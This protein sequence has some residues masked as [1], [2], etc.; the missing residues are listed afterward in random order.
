MSNWKKKKNS[1]Y[2]QSIPRGP[3]TSALPRSSVW[4][5]GN[6]LY[7]KI[8]GETGHSGDKLAKIQQ[9]HNA[10]TR[11]TNR[12]LYR[13]FYNKLCN[14]FTIIQS[15]YQVY[16]PIWLIRCTSNKAPHH[17]LEPINGARVCV[18]VCYLFIVE[19][20]PETADLSPL[21][22]TYY[23]LCCSLL[24]GEREV[25]SEI[26]HCCVLQNHRFAKLKRD[27]VSYRRQTV[28]RHEMEQGRDL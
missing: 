13:C 7:R 8:V 5:R 1:S 4:G 11:L 10:K 3:N 23:F 14:V 27:R 28:Y 18:C 9:N 25:G 15:T 17:L 12:Y 6:C 24:K 21:P 2:Q 26:Q 19:F 20:W 16:S 22:D